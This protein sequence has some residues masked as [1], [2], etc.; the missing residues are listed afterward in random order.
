MSVD[1]NLFYR[2]ITQRLFSHLRIE[3]ALQDTLL[4]LKQVMPA[5]FL[6]LQYTSLEAGVHKVIATANQ[7]TGQRMDATI[8]FTP[9]ARKLAY[10]RTKEVENS[11][12]PV[13][14]SNDTATDEDIRAVRD[15]FKLGDSSLLVMAL[16]IEGQMVGSL[17]VF[18]DGLDSY[19]KEDAK[20]FALLKQPAAVM[21]VS[22]YL[23]QEREKLLELLQDDNRFLHR[24]LQQTTGISIV[25][26][27]FGLKPVMDMVRQV[28]TRDSP[29]LLSGETGTGKDVIAGVIHRLS[30][31]Q[32]ES[33][34]TVNCG[35]IPDTLLDSELF[36]H[37]KGAFTGALA[38]KRGR[39]ERADRGTIF[40]DEIGELPLPAQVRLLRVLQNKEIERVG[41]TGPIPVD[42]RIIAATNKNLEEMVNEGTFREDLWFRLN[43]FPIEIPPLRERSA[44]IPALV[45]FFIERKS[46]E[47]KIR[48]IP[49]LTMST[50]EMLEAYRWPGNVREL[51]NI[52][53]RALIITQGNTLIIPDLGVKKT[54]DSK[55]NE[56]ISSGSVPTFDETVLNYLQGVLD[57]TQ[58]K[59]HGPG[60]AAEL[61]GLNPSTLRAKLRKLG[62]REN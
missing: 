3:E 60:G 41:G 26:E 57:I 43:V 59:I 20:L 22:S 21:L 30:A 9:S 23:Y 54:R 33:Y 32:S 50:L 52:I 55:I 56:T 15:F 5:D 62:L 51:E 35:A 24:E 27:E 48:P 16:D 61:S 36:G 44:D 12:I 39:F 25:G 11:D 58:G 42:N 8:P 18:A 45:E 19:T 46:R 47:L 29:V 37:E 10:E 13:V 34:I 14:L 2:E 31:R 1:Y 7:K 49:K 53:E 4:Y 28:A 6:V 40:L 38:L 17:A